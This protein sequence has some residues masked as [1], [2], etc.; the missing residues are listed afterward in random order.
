MGASRKVLVKASSTDGGYSEVVLASNAVE[1]GGTITTGYVPTAQADGTVD[2]A[3]VTDATNVE[4]AG[5]IMDDDFTANGLMER[6]AAGTYTVATVTAAGKAILDDAD[7]AAQRTTLGLGTI[8]TQAASSVAITGGTASGL[9]SLQISG[10]GYSSTDT[11]T[12]GATINTNCNNG[13]VHSVTLAGNR[14][15]ANPTNLKNGATYI[16]IIKQD[17]TGS[18]EL[19]FGNVFKFPGG[20]APTLSTGAN[21]VDIITAVS[22]GTNLFAN[23]VLDFS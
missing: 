7:A 21:A 19:S 12:D 3:A 17:A 14:T 5:A 10:Q 23:A 22:D 20:T 4:A 15:L 1:V 11:L 9:S 18:R 6:T 16:W 2:W 8:A 13:N